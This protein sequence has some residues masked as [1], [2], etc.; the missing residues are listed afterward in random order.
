MSDQQI[1]VKITDETLKGSYSNQMVV[2]H[3]KEEF[4]LDFM[5]IAFFPPPGQGVVTAK[6]I[7][8]PAHFKRMVAAMADNLKKYEEQFGKIE[9]AGTEQNL[10]SSSSTGGFGFNAK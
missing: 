2:S 8:N 6:I 9:E 7:T 4:V 5:N 1:N 3:T 10:K